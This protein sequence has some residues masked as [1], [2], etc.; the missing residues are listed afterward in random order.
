MDPE[1]LF[2]FTWH[3]YAVDPNVDYS[4]EPSTLV[5]FHLAPVEGGT[6]LTVTESGFNKIPEHRRFEAFR[7]N[8][9]GW[10]IQIQNINEYV[11]QG[12]NS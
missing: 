4:G 6:R 8:E 10:E 1:R 9:G 12:K 3:P 11:G 5:E 2:S 7:K